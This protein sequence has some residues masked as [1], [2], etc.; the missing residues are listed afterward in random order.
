MFFSKL[1]DKY[2]FWVRL[3]FQALILFL[4]TMYVF[5]TAEYSFIG[6]LL[7]SVF[8]SAGSVIFCLLT[9]G[10]LWIREES[11]V[12]SRNELRGAYLEENF[13]EYLSDWWR[14]FAFCQ[15]PTI[16]AMSYGIYSGFILS[17][18][19]GAD[20]G[21]RMGIYLM[22][23]GFILAVPVMLKAERRLNGVDAKHELREQVNELTAQFLD[24]NRRDQ[25]ELAKTI[26]H[27]L[28]KK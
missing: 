21:I 2:Y 1:L 23:A 5:K 8:S 18:T 10:W 27:H 13:D 20:F 11:N 7:L 26:L 6:R 4:L 3:G 17:L 9:G 14:S 28:V 22:A 25:N 15:E 19:A 16:V 12:Q 24:S